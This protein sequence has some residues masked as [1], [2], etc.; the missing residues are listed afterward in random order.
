M[1]SKGKLFKCPFCEK[2]FNKIDLVEHVNDDHDEMIPEKY[3]ALRVVYD[4]I[5]CKPAGYNGKCVI[6]G[7]P[8]GWNNEKGKYNRLCDKK[9]CK[10]AY[11][12][13]HANTGFKSPDIQEKLLSQ[14]KISGTY[15]MSDGMEKTYTGTYEKKCLEFLDKV[16]KVRSEDIM[17]PGIVLEYEYD[18]QKHMYISDFFYAPYNLIIEVKDGGDNPNRK[19]MIEYRNKTTAKEKYII[20]NTKYNYLRLT[21]NDFSQLL[22]VFFDLKMASLD[23]NSTERVI[24]INE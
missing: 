13:L 23:E 14:R 7:A 15:V 17:A 11:T 24:R 18:G 20:N 6:C 22:A 9:A 3:S 21:N 16:L 19:E 5:N 10:K 12:K 1:G 4:Y 2:K 8:S